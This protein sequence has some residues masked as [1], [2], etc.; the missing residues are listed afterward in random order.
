MS[1]HAFFAPSSMGKTAYCSY[2]PHIAQLFDDEDSQEAKEGT[3]A[4]WVLEQALKFQ[5]VDGIDQYL[6]YE[7][8]NGVFITLEI[9]E[10]VIE[11]FNCIEEL[12]TSLGLSLSDVSSEQR[13]YATQIHPELCWGTT[14]IKFY[15]KPT[16]TVYVRDFKH[17]MLLVEAFECWQLIAYACGLL[18][19]HPDAEYVDLG[20]IQPPPYHKD[21]IHRSWVISV[22]RL[23]GYIQHL[24]NQC[25]ESLTNPRMVT[26]DHCRYCSGR[27]NC[28]AFLNS[29]CNAIDMSRVPALA[30]MSYEQ[31]AKM[32]IMVSRAQ[33]ALKDF[34]RVSETELISKIQAGERIKGLTLE[35]NLGRSFWKYNDEKIIMV[36]DSLGIPNNH[37]VNVKTPIKILNSLPK[38]DFRIKLLEPYMDRKVTK[39]TLVVDDG[40]AAERAFNK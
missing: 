30:D 10:S 6:N 28:D 40:S 11:G 39:P 9:I 37:D 15:H 34:M 27:L 23:G 22:E 26:G 32:H 3:A 38:D 25:N 18:S 19:E 29:V 36:C 1:E 12:V 4:H 21:G 33:T 17:G 24:A 5:T 16:K 8:E 2:A 20:I 31:L 14:D 35:Q 13:V 7:H